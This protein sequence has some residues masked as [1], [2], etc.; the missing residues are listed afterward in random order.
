MFFEYDSQNWTT[1][2]LNM[3]PRIDFFFSK[4]SQIWTHFNM[5]QRKWTRFPKFDSKNWTLFTK[6]LKELD[7]QRLSDS[8]NKTFSWLVELNFFCFWIEEIKPSFSKLWFKLLDLF[9]TELTEL[10]PLKYDSQK[11]HRIWTL[12]FNM[13]QKKMTPF[14]IMTQRIFLF[15][16]WTQR[17]MILFFGNND[18]KNWAFFF[19]EA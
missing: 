18:P 4:K 3:T 13:S 11:T 19:E 2:F 5:T 8:N 15:T 1:L 6:G 12:L 14:L 7:P 17:T 10:N 9:W 16:Y